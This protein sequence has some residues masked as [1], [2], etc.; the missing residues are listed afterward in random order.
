MN[1]KIKNILIIF[2]FVIFLNSF[3]I[4]RNSLVV[5]AG[6]CDRSF[7][8]PIGD[9]EGDETS[10][11]IE[12]VFGTGNPEID[13]AGSGGADDATPDDT[14]DSDW[15][16][17]GGETNINSGG[18]STDINSGSG[19]GGGGIVVLP[20]FLKAGTIPE[21]LGGIADFLLSYIA[22]PFAVLMLIWAGFRFVTAQGNPEAIKKAKSNFIWTIGGVTLVL[23]ANLLVSFV[24]DF[25]SGGNMVSEALDRVK[26]TLNLLIGLLFTLVTVYFFWGIAE[27]VKASGVGNEE[28]IKKGKR[29]MVWGILGMAI[30]G[31]AWGIVEIIVDYLK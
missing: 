4:F 18:G 24:T 22:I 7:N 23:A 5:N 8:P 29:H 1:K 10:D 26:N 9:C 30:M 6:Y 27:F 20:N 13:D 14:L 25:L 3:F 12:P 19:N 21:L 17:M 2:F 28:G 31:A 16:G 15:S 11:S